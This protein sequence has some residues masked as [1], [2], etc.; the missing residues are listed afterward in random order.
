M[1]T[2]VALA[3]FFVWQAPQQTPLQRLENA[4]GL[5]AKEIADYFG[6]RP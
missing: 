5:I 1:K 4:I 3:A 6:Y 2:F